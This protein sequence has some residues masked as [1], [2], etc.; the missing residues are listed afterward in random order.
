MAFNNEA[1]LDFLSWLFAEVW[2]TVITCFQTPYDFVRHNGLSHNH[3]MLVLRAFL[4]QA[5][6]DLTAEVE[7]KITSCDSD[8]RRSLTAVAACANGKELAHEK[9]KGK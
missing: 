5:K 6:W 2:K 1:G 8:G 7:N 3:I 9:S 4:T